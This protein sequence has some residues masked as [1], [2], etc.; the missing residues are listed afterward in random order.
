MILINPFTGG[1][2]DAAPEA[3]EK[4]RTLGFMDPALVAASEPEPEPE[5]PK[6]EKPK[7]TKA[8]KK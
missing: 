3:V 2:V 5:P 1:E 6:A 8:A 7:A 4:L